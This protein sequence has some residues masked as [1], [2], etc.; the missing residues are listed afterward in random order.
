MPLTMLLAGRRARLRAVHGGRGMRGKL[1]AMGLAPGSEVEVLRNS[2]G[3]PF[4]VRVHN[5]RIVIG[6]G[7]ASR[8]E[9]E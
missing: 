3:G 6:R 5:C 4:I 8:I 2:R 1:A 7:M 9:V